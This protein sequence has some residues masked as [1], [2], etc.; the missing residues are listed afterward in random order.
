MSSEITTT[1]PRERSLV[2][3]MAATYGMGTRDFYETL[4]RTIMPNAN[5]SKEQ[6]AAFLLVANKH[7]LDPFAREIFAFPGK[8]GGVQAIV[9]VDGWMTLANRHPQFD[10]LTFAD[11]TEGGKLI[12]VTARVHRKDREHPTEVTEYMSEC[13]RN[14]DTW[15]Q[16][17]A[18]M[19]RHKATI[20]AIR[21]AFGFSGIMEHDEYERMMERA[22]RKKAADITHL[23]TAEN[24]IVAEPAQV[25]PTHADTIPEWADQREELV[26]TPPTGTPL[27]EENQ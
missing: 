10:G 18:R 19:L 13:A 5:V 26:L 22:P 2:A 11:H 16:W 15:R 20:Q 14:T 21:Y 12:S 7:G 27:E 23:L 4:T 17:P 1:A 24:E 6:V 8:G 25:Q 9:S 3:T